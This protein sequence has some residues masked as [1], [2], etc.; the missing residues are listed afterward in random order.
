MALKSDLIADVQFIFQSRWGVRDGRVV[1]SPESLKLGN[2]GI[3]VNATVLY[4]DLA[5]STVLVQ[6]HPD[7][8]AAEVYKTFL[9]CA[10]K[11]IRAENGEITAYDGDRIMAVYIGDSKNTQAV[12]TAQ[13]INYV[14]REIV[15]P[16]QA[17]QYPQRAYTL[18][19]VIGIDTSA[20]LVAIAGVRG[21]NDLIWIG[22]AA[23]YAAKLAAMDQAYPIWITE[24]VYNNMNDAVKLQ[25]GTGIN[26]WEKRLWTAMGNVPIY[27]SQSYWQL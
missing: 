17:R 1:P 10:A 2:D 13:K 12:R 21:A 16:A 26:L 19:H 9:N 25:G 22:R 14:V 5:D 11:I 18:Q 3:R 27:R 15:R 4:A 24:S 7:M 6:Q 20:L 23:N 8:F